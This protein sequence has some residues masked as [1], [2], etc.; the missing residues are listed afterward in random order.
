[1]G[2]P[3]T[4]IKVIDTT[5]FLSG[6]YCTMLLGDMGAD[7][8][9]V[10][11]PGDGDALRKNAPLIDGEGA[12]FLYTNRNKQSI[13]LDITSDEGR[14]I[15]IDLVKEADVFVENYRPRVKRKLKLDYDVLAGH[16]PR[17]IYCS[18]SGFGQ[19]GLWADRPGFDQIAQGMSGLMSVTGFPESIPTRVGV[20]IGDSLAGLFGAYG[21]LAALLE[22]ERSGM[23][24]Y[25]HTSLLESLIA[26]LG[27]QAAIYFSMG[28]A[29]PRQGNDHATIAPYGVYKT[30]D[31]HIN[32]AAGTDAMWKTLAKVLNIDN[33]LVNGPFATNKDRM[34]NKHILRDAMEAGLATATSDEWIRGLNDAGIACGPIYTIDQARRDAHIQAQNMFI[35]A[36]GNGSRKVQMIGFPVKMCRTGCAVSRLPP[37]LGQDTDAIL[38]RLG[39]S[40][41][42]IAELRRRKVI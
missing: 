20:A 5:G 10:E 15:L 11:R 25:I 42:D 17:L 8:I 7:V 40:E 33:G 24:Q 3:L 29:P 12:Y 37:K 6:P 21:I 28:Q 39:R 2:Q 4:G 1:M 18:I 14:S 35:E 9:K 34:A 38:S 22:R 31:G 36:N 26:V 23:G 32:I 41:A 16:N 27:Y 30:K 13:T 19:T